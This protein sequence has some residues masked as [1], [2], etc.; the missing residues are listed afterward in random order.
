MPSAPMEK[1]IPND[2]IHGTDIANCTVAS[3]VNCIAIQTET[4]HSTATTV[5]T[6]HL[7]LACFSNSRNKPPTKGNA[8][9]NVSSI[10]SGHC[11]GQ[12]DY[13]A[14]H[15]DE[16][17]ESDSAILQVARCPSSGDNTFAK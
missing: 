17:V 3:L 1:F 13:D 14:D 16:D 9:R 10:S 12:Y 8:M 2:V 11:K 7:G 6:I 4:T 15:H 5:V